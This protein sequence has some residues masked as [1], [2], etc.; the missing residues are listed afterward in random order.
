MACN[1]GEGAFY[2]DS[3]QNYKSSE[4][5]EES[6]LQQVAPAAPAFSPQMPAG[7]GLGIESRRRPGAIGTAI[8]FLPRVNAVAKVAAEMKA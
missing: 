8:A 7:E 1:L 4:G 5:A 2:N 3:G 6:I